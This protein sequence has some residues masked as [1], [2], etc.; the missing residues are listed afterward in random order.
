MMRAARTKKKT[1][2]FA[3]IS[4]R[5]CR[6]VKKIK[7]TGRKKAPGLRVKDWW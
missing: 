4:E 3:N 1:V 7:M 6:M 2:N 5:M